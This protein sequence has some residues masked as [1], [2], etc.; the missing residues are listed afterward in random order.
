MDGGYVAVVKQFIAGCRAA[1][2]AGEP[3]VFG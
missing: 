3:L 1:A 2:E